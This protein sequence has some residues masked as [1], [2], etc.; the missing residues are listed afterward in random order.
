MPH[1]SKL[2]QKGLTRMTNRSP[3]AL[4]IARMSFVYFVSVFGNTKHWTS[5]SDPVA[6]SARTSAEPS[7]SHI[8]SAVTFGLYTVRRSVALL[9]GARTLDSRALV[10]GPA[11]SLYI[12]FGPPGHCH[13]ETYKDDVR[14]CMLT[15]YLSLPWYHGTGKG[16]QTILIVL[17]AISHLNILVQRLILWQQ[18]K[19]NDLPCNTI[20]EGSLY[21]PGSLLYLIFDTNW[22]S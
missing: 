19:P 15:S 12:C 17:R 22:Y 1:E 11:A 5:S 21:R 14:E 20:L 2:R 3:I 7:K 10:C 8:S 9:V 13:Y 16:N 18:S 6:A 4:P